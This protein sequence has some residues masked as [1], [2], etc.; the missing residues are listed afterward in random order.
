MANQSVTHSNRRISSGRRVKCLS[1]YTVIKR[2]NRRGTGL[3]TIRISREGS[4][5]FRSFGRYYGTDDSGRV[6]SAFLLL[7]AFA[8]SVLHEGERCDFRHCYR[9]AR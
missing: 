9:A 2:L 4:E 1:E 5:R 8:G 3:G 6:I 7:S